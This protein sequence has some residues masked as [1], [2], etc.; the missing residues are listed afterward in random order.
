IK[1]RGGIAIVQDPAEALHVDMPRHAIELN[2]VD[3][4]LPVGKIADALSAVTRQ[5]AS[6]PPAADAAMEKEARYI[7]LDMDVIEDDNKLG[8]PSSCSCP[9]CGGV[10]WE[11]GEDEELLRF[12]CRVGHAYTSLALADGQHDSLEKALWA[13]FRSLEENAAFARRLGVRA[14]RAGDS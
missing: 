1:N 14:R 8:K 4:V 6:E 10:L 12:R 11:L 13:A 2:E 7:E 3:Y 9:D 5:P